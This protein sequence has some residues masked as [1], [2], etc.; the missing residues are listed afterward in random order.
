MSIADP[1]TLLRDFTVAKKPITLEGD[2]IVFGRTRFPRGALTA[3]RQSAGSKDYYSL[4][5]AWSLLQKGAKTNAQ[6]AQWCGERGI[7][8]IGF[9]D[10]DALLE[11]LKGQSE[12]SA[13]VDYSGYTAV[14]PIVDGEGEAGEGAATA[15]GADGKAS[16]PGRR[17]E[18]TAEEAVAIEEAKDIFKLVLA[19]PIGAPPLPAGTA[20]AAAS[21]A[22][23]A[24]AE[25]GGDA[26]MQDAE[27][28]DAEDAEGGG[29]GEGGKK[30]A[31]SGS[32]AKGKGGESSSGGKDSMGGLK[33][34][35]A[36][37]KPF[38]RHDRERTGAIVKR[39]RVMRSRTTMLLAPD[40]KAF[41]VVSQVLETFKQRNKR[42]L[43]AKDRE[44]RKAAQLKGSSGS[45]GAAAAA[46]S[47]SAAKGK[48]ASSGAAGAAAAAAAGGAAAAPPP[49]QLGA[50]RAAPHASSSSRSG[51]RGG[52]AHG[53][54]STVG[55]IIVPPA[56]TAIVNMYNARALFEHNQFTSGVE[57]KNA[58]GTKESSVK[59]THT[60]DDGSTASFILLDNPTAKLSTHEWA[61]V[62]AVIAAG[63]AWQFKGW[64]YAKGETEIFSKMAG[65]YI[66]FT[67]EIPNQLT[68]GWAVHNLI[69]SREKTRSYE[70]S[71]MMMNLWAKVQHFIA[72]HKPHMLHKP[73]HAK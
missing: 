54:K 45:S 64:P 28:A 70:V 10:R 38:I 4:D 6:Y 1:L 13:N 49:Q 22:S 56:I 32:A 24:P 8:P 53:G 18:L 27:M 72:V 31:A 67:D 46:S 23:V 16:K 36:A 26:E 69:F 66:R 17:R 9:R 60:F 3:Y 63:N 2:H 50:P 57:V 47:S 44:A 34:A 25:A 42:V 58:G 48:D 51:S 37:A 20:A 7:T 73:G 15:V 68:K 41:P 40:S 30:A 21:A 52:A 65:F 35:I 55:Y 19:Q 14:K 61:N 71:T 11:Y 59:I 39:E 29:G 12:S 33:E 43:D 62:V 5:A